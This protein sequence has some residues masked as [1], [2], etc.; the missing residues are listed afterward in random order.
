ML[1]PPLRKDFD[2]QALWQA[3]RNGNIQTIGTDHCPFNLYGQ[4]DK[5]LKDF[6]K[7]AN[8]AGSIEHRLLL[9]FTYGVL[10]NKIS[11][12]KFVEI[13]ST[14]PA[15]IFGLTNKGQLKEAQ[16]LLQESAGYA[17]DQ[18]SSLGGV[19][20]EELDDLSKEITLDA[21][22]IVEK[23]ETKLNS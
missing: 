5:G 17:R 8:G 22:N 4:K 16:I 18:G 20:Q 2:N 3:V 19:E 12:Q 11:L 13:T 15:K 9:M 1:S 6:T 14:N 23:K 7:I 21:Q 10:E